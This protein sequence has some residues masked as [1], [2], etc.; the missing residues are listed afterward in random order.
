[1]CGLILFL[2]A[3]GLILKVGVEN[4]H[5]GSLESCVELAEPLDDMATPKVAGRD[6]PPR[7]RAKRITI[8]ENAIASRAKAIKL[9]TTDPPPRSRNRLKAER[10]RT[11]LEEKRLSTDGVINRYREI[12]RTLRS[13]VQQEKRKAATFKSVEYVVVRGKKKDI[14]VTPSYCTNIR[15]IEVEYLKDEAEKKK[16]APVDT[17]LVVDNNTLP[18]KAVLP[19]LAPGPSG[20]SSVVPSVTPSSSIT[21]LLPRRASRLEATISRMIERAFTAVVTPLSVSIQALV[22]RITVCE[23]GKG[24]TKEV[25]TLK[26]EIAELR[27]DVD[28]LKS[29]DMYMIFG[30]MEILDM[31]TNM[32]IS[33]ATTRDEV[34]VEEMVAAESE[35]ETDE[36]QLDTPMVDPSGATSNVTLSLMPQQME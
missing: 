3:M 18:V 29:T 12:Y 25:M 36:E 2:G 32:D 10:L 11:I 14:E 34:R 17:S 31:P 16:A 27:K 20:I 15:L 35:V 22:A 4:R 23:Q 7:I 9:L 5:I 26:A 30:T 24:A 21:S 28:Q 33:L 8:D 13:L 6:M 1:M 19:T